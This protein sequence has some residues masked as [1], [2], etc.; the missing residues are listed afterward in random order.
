MSQSLES[1]PTYQ[2][3]P[4][5]EV[6]PIHTDAIGNLIVEFFCPY[7]QQKHEHGLPFQDDRITPSHRSAHCWGDS[8]LR[9]G[10]YFIV[11]GKGAINRN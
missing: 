8:P 4:V 11:L 6:M 10:G 2:G 1:L 9:K 7:C 3:R 5:F